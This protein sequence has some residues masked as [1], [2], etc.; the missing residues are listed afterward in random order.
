V[1][2][3]RPGVLGAHGWGWVDARAAFEWALAEQESPHAPF[4]LAMVLWWLELRNSSSIRRMSWYT[5]LPR[6]FTPNGWST[7]L[8]KNRV[9]VR[10]RVVSNTISTGRAISI[11]PSMRR[12]TGHPSCA[13]HGQHRNAASVAVH[14]LP[15]RRKSQLVLPAAD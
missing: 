11:S 10:L 3:S 6:R 2:S 5:V 12:L 7:W 15:D 13:A 4:G 14:G 1:S 8:K 9:G